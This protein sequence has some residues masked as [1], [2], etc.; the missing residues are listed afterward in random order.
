[1]GGRIE[2]QGGPYQVA[3]LVKLAAPGGKP[4]KDGL[5]L[6]HRH[7]YSLGQLCRRHRLPL[8]QELQ[9]AGYQLEFPAEHYFHFI[10]GV[11]IQPTPGLN[12]VSDG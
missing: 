4:V 6:C 2:R 8:C 3:P 10:S 7:L 5:Y 11:I 1:M 9:Q 12:D